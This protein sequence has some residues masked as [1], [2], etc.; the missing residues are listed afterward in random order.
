MVKL[1]EPPQI[2]DHYNSFM[3]EISQMYKC[4]RLIVR[5]MI[6]LLTVSCQHLVPEQSL[7]ARDVD[8]LT[9]RAPYIFEGT[10]S[11]TDSSTMQNL[12]VDDPSA[13]VTVNEVLRV[14]QK[15]GNY[16]DRKITVLIKDPVKDG[17]RIIFFTE[18]LTFGRSLA[19]RELGRI[20]SDNN[21]LRDLTIQKIK[22]IPARL[23]RH[24][25]SV[26]E[27]VVTGRVDAI[28]SPP[29]DQDTQFISE[30]YPYWRVAK[31]S[32]VSIEAGKYNKKTLLVPFPLSQ[33]VMWRDRPKFA[34]GQEGIWILHSN[35]SDS[36]NISLFDV[37]HRSDFL[38]LKSLDFVR[39]QIYIKTHANTAKEDMP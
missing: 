19:V 27:L 10:I 36:A 16:T 11:K 6:L 15:L 12:R 1:T 29:P 3:E 28:L 26:S 30:H 23:F 9:L 20:S 22:D 7:N 37:A 2:L 5:C 14:P 8:Q 33:D 39:Q 21:I 35:S 24:H 18:G 4:H 25:V 38:P 17:E 32:I 13:V 31:I 34:L